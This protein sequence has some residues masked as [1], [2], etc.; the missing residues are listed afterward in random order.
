LRILKA[1]DEFDPSFVIGLAGEGLHRMQGQVAWI[2]ICL[3]GKQIKLRDEGEVS[4][5]RQY[6]IYLRAIMKPIQ[7]FA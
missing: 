7:N 4:G 2:A 6:F 3:L 1:T 5:F